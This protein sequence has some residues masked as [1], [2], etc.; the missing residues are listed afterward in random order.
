M[1]AELDIHNFAIIDKLKLTLSPGFNVLTGETGA[2]KSII[3]D[4]VTL[5]L[6]GRADSSTVRAGT[7][8]A[9]IEGVFILDSEQREALR[10]SLE[11]L[12][13]EGEGES[14]ILAR[15]LSATGRSVGRINGRAVTVK[16]LQE[17]GER[18][19]DIHGQSEHL[20]LLRVRAHIDLLDRYAGLTELRGQ[21]AAHV[22]ELNSIRGQL[23]TLRR[24]ARELA[25]R[26]D[27]LEFQVQ[28]IQGAKLKP[29]E[30]QA[31]AQ[32]RVLLTNAE[33]LVELSTGIYQSLYEGDGEQRAALDLLGSALRDLGNLEKLDPRLAEQRQSAE[34]AVYV[35][36]DLAH[37]IRDYRDN[38][39]F[40]PA[41]LAQVEERLDLIFRLKRKY[42]ESIPE[43]LAFG[44]RAAQELESISHSEERIQ[45]LETEEQVRLAEVAEV[46][47]ELSVARQA[48]AGS[49][50]RAVEHEL[51]NLR[52]SRTRFEVSLERVETPDGVEIDGKGF[53]FDATGIDRVE[54]LISPNPGEPL[55]PLVK[56]ASG[57]ETSR[58]ML[59]LKTVL[60]SADT[61]PTL[62]F[63]E[64]DS[65]IGGR[66]G[67]IVGRKLWGLTKQGGRSPERSE[68]TGAG[69]QGSTSVSLH[70]GHAEH[71]VVC[72]THLPQ[73]A[74]YGDAHY[75]ISKRVVGERTSTEA[76]MLDSG[77]RVDE[78]MQMLGSSSEAARQTAA[79]ML[80]EVQQ[81]K[82]EQTQWRNLKSP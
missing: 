69:G 75:Q 41:R 22:R 59:A 4:A 50:A 19:V 30:E 43:I 66:V 1:L 77:K 62:I 12:G 74:V 47:Q 40:S 6:G 67:E 56:I 63:D 49:L 39:E 72:V 78:I 52:M 2:G 20:S 26:V 33:R 76:R 70:L 27:L 16:A 9:R 11:E 31:L 14:I 79:A 54:F 51:E 13:L 65:G 57:G 15:E 35:L 53:A 71:Q 73:I 5:L 24:D 32:E 44:E 61:T 80:D 45:V 58:L 25:R 48:A 8:Q 81:W 29:G 36:E 46:A 37:A 21:V 3:I 17:I 82:T 10:P 7:D 42:G 60:A 55:K 64:I 18:L 28:E 23:A 34:T 38:I 68:G